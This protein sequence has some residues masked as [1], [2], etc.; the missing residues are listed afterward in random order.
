MIEGG[1]GWE[2]EET[3]EAERGAQS[4]GDSG[5]GGEEF[6]LINSSSLPFSSR[7]TEATRT[8]YSP[9]QP[10]VGRPLLA[11]PRSLRGEPTT[12]VG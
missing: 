10:A 8:T 5:R 11:L 2:G 1:G 4:E 7:T 6:H 3:S 12:G 9:Q